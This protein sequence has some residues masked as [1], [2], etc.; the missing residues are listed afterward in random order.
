MVES[1]SESGSSGTMGQ[2]GMVGYLAAG[3]AV[4]VAIGGLNMAI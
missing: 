3:L 1:P 2:P 4:A